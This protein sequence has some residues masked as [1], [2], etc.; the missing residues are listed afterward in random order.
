MRDDRL[1][2]NDILSAA[3]L[4]LNFTEGK[5]RTDLGTD[6]MLQSAIL[7]QLFVIGEAATR[8]SA[9]TKQKCPD[10]P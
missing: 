4:I 10:I 6:S 7:H 1:R 3:D 9:S 5:N 8:I 2:L